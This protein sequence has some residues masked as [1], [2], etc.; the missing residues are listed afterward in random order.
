MKQKRG[1]LL[2][3]GIIFV[4]IAALYAI[5]AIVAIPSVDS[6]IMPIIEAEVEELVMIGEAELAEETLNTMKLSL[7]I[8]II[9]MVVIAI[10]D[11]ILGIKLIK[12]S[13]ASDKVIT[14][15]RKLIVT[16]MV[17]SIFAAGLMV[18]ILLCL[19]LYLRVDEEPRQVVVQ[20]IPT[21][22]M[23]QAQINEKYE[24]KIRR[25]QDLRDK[26]AITKEEYQKLLKQIFEE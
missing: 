23:N 1:L 5:I 13:K 26:G 19:A 15:K 10:V 3:S 18:T 8:V 25:L 6:V 21:E 22:N 14:E 17:V 20:T 16:A 4:V 11:M 12:L 2:A 7:N 9:S 24:T